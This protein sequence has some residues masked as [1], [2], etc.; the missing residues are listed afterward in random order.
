MS[1]KRSIRW[2]G[3]FVVIVLGVLVALGVDDWR[4]YRTDRELEQH[5]LDRLATDLAADATDLAVAQSMVARRVWVL[6][7]LTI[8][9]D[10][11]VPS[12]QAPR[13]RLFDP[14]AGDLRER[15]AGPGGELGMGV[16]AGAHGRSAQ[17]QNVPK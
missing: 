6:D 13:A 14:E 8:E 5:L 2:I 4:Q 12:V 17:G 15:L 10:E 7:E 9:I 11:E 16:D 3:E 1:E